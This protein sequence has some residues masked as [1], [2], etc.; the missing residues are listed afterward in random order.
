MKIRYILLVL[1][2]VILFIL[3]NFYFV[4]IKTPGSVVEEKDFVNTTKIEPAKKLQDMDS[5][6][7]NI[8]IAEQN[9]ETIKEHGIKYLIVDVGNTL[10]NGLIDTPQKQITG[11]LDLIDK[12]KNEKN[13]D[14]VVLPYSEINTYNYSFND[15]LRENFL[16]D[17]TNLM[18][19]GFDGIYLDIEPVKFSERTEFL[20]FL[21][22]VGSKIPAGKILGVYTGTLAEDK[23]NNNEW[24]WDKDFFINV[25]EKVDLITVP[26]Y[27]YGIKSK[28]EYEN[29]LRRQVA[30]IPLLNLN[31]KLNFAIPTHNEFPETINIS[32]PV[33]YSEEE[34][35]N[36]NGF[37][38]VCLFAE[39]TMDE[40]E[41]EVYEEFKK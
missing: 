19:L 9:L 12:F 33:Y 29:E 28:E 26:G 31:C 41:W 21:E 38:G 30:E 27:D 34:K 20:D 40:K 5:I 1:I 4:Y 7:T 13:Y 24:A 3:I 17:Y 14:F 37:N 15:E 16:I 6:V 2:L 36:V 8:W 35:S 25:S 22:L 10:E 11:F 32:L 39:W 23:N 18:N